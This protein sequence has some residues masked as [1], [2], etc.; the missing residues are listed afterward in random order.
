[1]RII[2]AR[3]IDHMRSALVI[4]FLNGYRVGVAYITRLEDSAHRYGLA[5]Q[6]RIFGYSEQHETRLWLVWDWYET[7]TS[8]EDFMDKRGWE[9]PPSQRQIEKPIPRITSR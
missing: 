7:V 4:E 8:P 6:D 5:G 9:R 2:F 3:A 1:M